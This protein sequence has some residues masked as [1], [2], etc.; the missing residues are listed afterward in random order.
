MITA[1]D[2]SVVIDILSGDRTFGPRSRAALTDARGRGGVVACEVVWAE[3][4]GWASSPDEATDVM[5]RMGIGFGPSTREAS[6]VAG[7]SLASYRRGGGTRERMLPDFLIGAHAMLHADRLL[8]RDRG[9]YRRY[10]AELVVTDP[11]RD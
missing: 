11:S 4:A 6:L 5:D 9:F 7:R 1:L 10:F 8:T 3:I 2:S